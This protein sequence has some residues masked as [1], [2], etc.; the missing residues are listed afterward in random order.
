[1]SGPLSTIH[2]YRHIL[3]AAKRFPSVKKESIIKEIK[4]EFRANRGLSDQQKIEHSRSVAE[5]G[6]SDLQSYSA[7]NQGSGF[8]ITLKGATG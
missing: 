7:M 1:M 5:R 4:A 8:A 2:L 6:L 3:K